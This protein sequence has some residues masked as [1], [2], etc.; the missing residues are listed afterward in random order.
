MADRG[1]GDLVKAAGGGDE[2]A[3]NLLVERYGRLVWAVTRSFRLSPADAADVFQT[4]WLRFAEHLDRLRE[5]DRAGSWLAT[6]CRHECLRVLRSSS[7]VVLS[8]DLGR[9]AGAPATSEPFEDDIGRAEQ[10]A[11]L[12]TAFGRLPERDQR[13]LAMVV[14][15]TCSYDDICRELGMPR[16]SIGPTRAR[17][18]ERLGREY[19]SIYADYFEEPPRGRPPEKRRDQ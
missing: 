3:W 15:P 9:L 10:R 11:A 4:V 16:G 14:D 7:R 8:D 19:A 2:Q 17:C 12:V 5:P 1:T 6:T 13:L 18:L